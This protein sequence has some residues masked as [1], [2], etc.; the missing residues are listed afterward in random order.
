MFR[1]FS[2][3]FALVITLA[4]AAAARAGD[5]QH[6]QVVSAM[7]SADQS[8]VFVTGTGFGKTP[9]VALDGILLGGVTVNGAGTQLQAILPALA[10]GSYQLLVLG[11]KTKSDDSDRV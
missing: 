2:M 3:C 11:K 1:R 7:V 5:D 4:T 9:L 6:T 8:T 10:P